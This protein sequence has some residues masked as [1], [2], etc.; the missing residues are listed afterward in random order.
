MNK[1]MDA[2]ELGI[3]GKRGSWKQYRPSVDPNAPSAETVR[4]QIWG[5]GKMIPKKEEE[6]LRG[7]WELRKEATWSIMWTD[8]FRRIWL[9]PSVLGQLGIVV[10]F[11]SYNTKQRVL[12][13]TWGKQKKSY[14]WMIGGFTLMKI[15]L[16]VRSRSVQSIMKW[17]NIMSPAKLKIFG[18]VGTTIPMQQQ[19]VC[20]GLV[21]SWRFQLSHPTCCQLCRLRGGSHPVHEKSASLWN[22]GRG[23]GPTRTAKRSMRCC[24]WI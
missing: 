21:S 5:F 2:A 18:V 22:D 14:G 3:S 8:W 4:D 9:L 1:R 17:Q 11:Q 6:D 16:V 12:R 20:E 19:K 13:A 24:F 7:P 15:S 10:P 23:E